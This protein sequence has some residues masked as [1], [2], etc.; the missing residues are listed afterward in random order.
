EG[1]EGPVDYQPVE[2]D[3]QELVLPAGAG[4]RTL[5]L[6]VAAP[7]GQQVKRAANGAEGPVLDHYSAE[8]IAHHLCEVGA[9]L[10]AAAGAENITAVFCD[11]LEVYHADWTPSMVA[12]FTARRGYDPLPLL[13]RLR[14]GH[15][16][17]CALRADYYRTLSE[18]QEENFLTP[19]RAW[20]HERGVAFRVQNYGRPPA[21]VSGYGCADL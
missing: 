8:A 11:S 5:L 4:P 14:V 10:L 1:V 6:A 16:E 9:P 17:V 2:T 13:Y 12:E 3:G 15:P 7:T 18:L 21:R 19:V 20:A